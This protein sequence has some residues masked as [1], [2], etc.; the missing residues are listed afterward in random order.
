MHCPSSLRKLGTKYNCLGPLGHSCITGFKKK[1]H[2]KKI[3]MTF[4]I[5]NICH[6]LY[7]CVHCVIW[8]ILISKTVKLPTFPMTAKF[9]YSNYFYDLRIFG[10][11]ILIVVSSEVIQIS[12]ASASMHVYYLEYVRNTFL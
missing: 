4:R 11:H 1:V 7:G 2:R 5:Q 8:T 10:R 6:F 3:E 12:S 9:L